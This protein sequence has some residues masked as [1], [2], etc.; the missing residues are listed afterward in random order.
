[1][2]TI[3]GRQLASQMSAA[4]AAAL[5]QKDKLKVPPVTSVK[6]ETSTIDVVTVE[7]PPKLTPT[8]SQ[9]KSVPSLSQPTESGK[10]T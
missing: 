3:A 8:V 9:P 10:F 1:M 5:E 2:E 6:T 7:M 4:A